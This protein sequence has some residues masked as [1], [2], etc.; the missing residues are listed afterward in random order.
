V[1]GDQPDHVMVYG[2]TGTGKSLITRHVARR[3][4]EAGGAMDIAYEYI[5]CKQF[6][7]EAQVFAELALQFNDPED[8]EQTVPEMGLSTARYKQRLWDALNASYDGALV[9]LD[10]M[11]KLKTENTVLELSRA[12]EDRKI[13]VPLGVIVISNRIGYI[14]DFQARVESSFDPKDIQTGPY[15]ANTLREIMESRSRAF[16]DGALSS[17]VIPKA[18]ALAAQEHG[19]ARKAMQILRHAGELA[20]R[21][22]ENTVTEDHVQEARREAEKNR[23]GETLQNATNQEK[24]M[25]LAL[26]QLT[27]DAERTR[28]KQSLHY[29]QYVALAK[30][31]EMNVLSQRRLRDLVKGYA[32]LEVLETERRNFGFEGGI[33]RLNRLLVNPEI[34]REVILLDHPFKPLRNQLDELVIGYPDPDEQ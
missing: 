19:D 34:V 30:A 27:L 8:T 28:F 2:K 20:A 26:A 31:L 16:R 13:D 25:L 22:E 4:C 24:L 12:V 5:D 6:K 10:E 21:R 32:L 17:G 33:H 3:A 18:A 29:D 23:F 7:T 1:R 15:D 11:D 14:E 9:I